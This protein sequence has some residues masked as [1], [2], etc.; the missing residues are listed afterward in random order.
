MM[1]KIYANGVKTTIGN[2]AD[3]AAAVN[4]LGGEHIECPV[5]DIVVDEVN[6]VVSTPAYM[7]ANSLVEANA[8][9]SKLVAKVIELA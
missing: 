8:G 6:K 5:D 1:P 3:T 7:L 2:D 9:I 4:Q